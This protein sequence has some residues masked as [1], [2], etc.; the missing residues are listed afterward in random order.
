MLVSS[1]NAGL[2]LAVFLRTTLKEIIMTFATFALVIT[3]PLAFITFFAEC[4]K[5]GNNIKAAAVKAALMISM[6]SA[7]RRQAYWRARQD[8]GITG[9]PVGNKWKWSKAADGLIWPI[10]AEYV[11]LCSA[12]PAVNGSKEERRVSGVGFSYTV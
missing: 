11:E 3:S 7:H 12:Q 10:D 1:T 8:A 4:Y 9:A 5:E 6:F 2:V